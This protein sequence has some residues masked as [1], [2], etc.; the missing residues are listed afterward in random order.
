MGAGVG[1]GYEV[2]GVVPAS[3][4]APA[5]AEAMARELNEAATAGHTVLPRGRGTRMDMG[6]LLSRIDR[7]VVTSAL[8]RVVHYEPADLT[9]TVEAGCDLS[10]LGRLLRENGQFLPVQATRFRGTVG[11][12][13]ATAPE[14]GTALGYGGVRDH[15][16]GAR[17]ALAD[18]TLVKGGGRVVKNV[19][20]YPLHRLLAGSFGTLGVL[21][22]ASFKVHPLPEAQ[23]SLLVAFATSERAFAFARRVLECGLEPVFANVLADEGGVFL[24]LGFDGLEPRVGAHVRGLPDLVAP[25]RPEGFKILSEE[26]QGALRRRLDDPAA[27][28]GARSTIRLT[29]L[30][31]RIETATGRVLEAARDAGAKVRLDARPGIGSAYVTLEASDLDTG[32]RALGAALSS[33]RESGHAVVASAPFAVRRAVDPWGPPPPDFFLMK[34]IKEALDPGGLFAAGRF[35]GGI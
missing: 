30:P 2:D 11:G 8:S 19:A 12:L 3:V 7:V 5:S 32:C 29:A 1:P 23:A 25:G 15:L 34:R 20:G 27:L 33:A 9:I 10:G 31:S 18:G 26:E 13:V 16:T 6:G 21:V 28:G 14:G 22:E 24:A 4:S 35:V 17:A